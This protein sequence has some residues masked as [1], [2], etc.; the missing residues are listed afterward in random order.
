MQNP[1]PLVDSQANQR[2]PGA[3]RVGVLLFLMVVVIAGTWAYLRGHEY[4]RLRVDDHL[5]IATHDLRLYDGLPY[6]TID[7]KTCNSRGFLCD[8]IE[9]HRYPRSAQGQYRAQN[10]T[11]EQRSGVILAVWGDR[12]FPLSEGS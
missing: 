3:T 1:D 8:T 11:L 2:A 4:D 7:I 10:V 5:Y 12:A 9:V 6:Y